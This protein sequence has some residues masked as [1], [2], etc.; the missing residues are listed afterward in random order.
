MTDDHMTAATHPAFGILDWGVA[1]ETYL[2]KPPAQWLGSE[3]EAGLAQIGARL[4]KH[5]EYST[6]LTKLRDQ[7]TDEQDRRRQ[8]FE[9]VASLFLDTTEEPPCP[10]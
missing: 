5:P 2:S 4:R 9:D 7:L 10:E 3:L 1:P 6:Q 8:L